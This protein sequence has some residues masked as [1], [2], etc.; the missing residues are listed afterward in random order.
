V[1]G[2]DE[3][4]AHGW[5]KALEMLP[6]YPRHEGK[7]T[8]IV[9]VENA[10]PIEYNIPIPSTVVFPG[11]QLT[12]FS[13]P[14]EKTLF[15]RT[16]ATMKSNGNNDMVINAIARARLSMPGAYTYLKREAL[17]R[18]RPNGTL[19]LNRNKPEHR[20]N[21]F[22]H[23]TEMYGAAAAVSELLLQSVDG[24]IRVFPAWPQDQEAA[25]THLRATGGF[26]VSASSVAGAVGEI[27]I[28]STVGG[29]CRLFSPWAGVRLGEQPL[30]PSE[31]GIIRF[32]TLAGE[33]YTLH[34]A[35]L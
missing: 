5:L 35:V 21:A 22:G 11:E 29:A 8:L 7:T 4:Q 20:F 1:L 27:R 12:F 34:E 19:T 31:G 18:L 16:I 6:D 25:F 33:T 10:E 3:D 23:Y 26:L 15:T 24:I 2:R 13:D 14:E 30:M 9:D 28:R 17:A 32:D